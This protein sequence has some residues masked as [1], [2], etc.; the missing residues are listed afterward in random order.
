MPDYAERGRMLLDIAREAIASPAEP[1]ARVWSELWLAEPAATFVTLRDSLG[2]LRGC[3]GTIDPHRALG[4]D[5]AHNAFAAA[6]RDP[7]F[8]PLRDLERATTAVEVSLLTPRRPFA[9]QSEA[10]A[11]HGLEPGTDGLVFEYHGQR[12]TFL[13]QVWENISDPLDFLCE[14]RRKA[15]LPAR[16]W[17]P[18]VKLSRYGVEK[19]R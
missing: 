5:V 16:F 13:P 8:P 7:R 14:L 12:A 4:E 15:G 2:D 9:A 10:E 19:H 1:V 17:H 18:D 11:V 3:I 6:Y